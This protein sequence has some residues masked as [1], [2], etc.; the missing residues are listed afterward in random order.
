[1]IV[2]VERAFESFGD[3]DH[4]DETSGFEYLPGIA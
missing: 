2:I 1:M 3:I 4:V